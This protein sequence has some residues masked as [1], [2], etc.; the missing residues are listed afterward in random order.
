[1]NVIGYDGYAIPVEP[2]TLLTTRAGEDWMLYFGP[3][4]AQPPKASDDL[5]HSV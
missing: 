2:E 4:T 1:V 5:Q 3:L